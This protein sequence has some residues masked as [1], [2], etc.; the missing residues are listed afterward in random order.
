LVES[1]TFSALPK[2]PVKVDDTVFAARVRSFGS[3]QLHR[4]ADVISPA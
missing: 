4:L 1:E 3:R 2:A